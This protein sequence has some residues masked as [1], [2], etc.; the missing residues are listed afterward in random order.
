[1]AQNL[2]KR[3][4]QPKRPIST[5]GDGNEVKVWIDYELLRKHQGRTSHTII[6]DPLASKNN[7]YLQLADVALGN[8]KTKNK[9]KAVRPFKS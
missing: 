7:R 5:P 8:D 3:K 1:M 6:H 2:V 9:A 4:A